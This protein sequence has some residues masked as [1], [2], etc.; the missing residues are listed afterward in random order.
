MPPETPSAAAAAAPASPVRSAPA[1][2]PA[3]GPAAKAARETFLVFFDFDRATLTPAGRGVSE[4]AIA[5]YNR[6]KSARLELTGYADL[7]GSEAYNLNLSRRRAM[8][9]DSYMLF[10]DVPA[11]E[12]GVGW[13]GEEDPRVPTPR[14]EPQ[15][16]RVEIVMS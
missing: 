1:L 7:V 11:S 10:K 4:D 12:I 2:P 6:D 8:S 3:A 13:R 16:R 14:R 15:N 9:V 5:A